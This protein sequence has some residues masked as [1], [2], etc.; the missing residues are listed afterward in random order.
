MKILLSLLLLCFPFYGAAQ[1]T[2][3]SQNNNG[4]EQID[5][6]PIREL[7]TEYHNGIKLLQNRFRIDYKVEEI[8]MVF[9]RKFGSAPIVLVRPDGSKIFQAQAIDYD[10]DWYDST[11]YDYIRMREPCRVRGKP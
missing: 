10:V 1:Q 9:F 5:T 6:T 3:D 7:G 11:T 2:G 8:T 4:V